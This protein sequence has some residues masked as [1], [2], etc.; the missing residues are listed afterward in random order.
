MVQ[1]DIAKKLGLSQARVSRLL[2]TAE[3]KGI[4]RRIVVPP[5]GLFS[6]LERSV[7]EKFGL[8]QVHIVDSA[9]ES[10][11]E[12]TDSLG[13]ALAS[14]FHLMPIEGKSVGFTSWSRSLR[15]FVYSLSPFPRVGASKIVEMLGGV[16]Q[17]S[18]QHLATS[19]TEIFAK[20]T[21]SEPVFLRVPGVVSSVLMKQALL[22]G[23]S[24][25]RQAL[26]EFDQLDIALVGI[27]N[28]DAAAHIQQDSNFFSDEQFE[29]AQRAG[30]VGEINLRFIDQQGNPVATELDELVVGVS[31]EQ[32]RKIDLRIG[33]SGGKSKLQAT[34]A[35][36]RGKWVDV[37][38]TDSDTATYLLKH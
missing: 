15:S 16:G 7:E 28:A 4:V 6:E 14:V 31:L 33:V 23:D 17:P 38:V 35:V 27:G 13:M 21:N 30:A 9:G 20:L 1:T 12:L 36:A 8:S 26:A 24:H 37:L 25:A 18:L 34:L 32:L 22:E 11:A 19:A 5:A 29:A 10:E 3:E 2:S